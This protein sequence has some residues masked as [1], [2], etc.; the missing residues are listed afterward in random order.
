MMR[1]IASRVRRFLIC[2][3]MTF[4]IVGGG[5]TSWRARWL[6]NAAFLNANTGEF[7]PSY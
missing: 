4:V 6:N 1:L 5:P 7:V 3:S 2:P